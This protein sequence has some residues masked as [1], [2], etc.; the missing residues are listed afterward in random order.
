[1]GRSCII[2]IKFYLSNKVIIYSSS[3]INKMD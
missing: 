3:F 2:Q 1:M